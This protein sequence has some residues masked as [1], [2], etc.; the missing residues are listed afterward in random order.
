LDT[1]GRSGVAVL[2]DSG[3]H[4]LEELINVHEISLG[5]NSGQWKSILVLRL[6]STVVTAVTINRYQRWT[7]WNVIR[8][9]ATVDWKTLQCHQALANLSIR[10]GVN[11]TTLG[12]TKELV[13]GVVSALASVI[14]RVLKITAM[15]DWVVDWG[16]RGLLL[17]GVVTVVSGVMGAITG[18]S[19]M[20]LGVMVVVAAG[21]CKVLQVSNHFASLPITGSLAWMSML[22]WRAK[23]DGVVGVCLHVLLE[24]LRT[25]EC[26]ATEIALVGL[27][28]DVDTNVRGDVITLHSGGTAL[29]PATGQ[30]EVVCA[31]ASNVL[32]TDVFKEGLRGGTSLR[33]LVPLT[34]QVVISCNCWSGSLSRRGC[35]SIL[36]WLLCRS[37]RHGGYMCR[38]RRNGQPMSVPHVRS[39]AT[40]TSEVLVMYRE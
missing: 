19:G 14:G 34:G 40:L 15:A 37:G 8:D 25:L 24:I 28:G 23:K 30:V 39:G 13:Q 27:Q 21:S 38:S 26:L 22:L 9:A 7:S 6:V 4:L 31:L 29:I 16:V 11:L 5:T 20:H 2:I 35:R 1:S 17:R 36:L 3:L 10:A 18:S 32:L 12:I 33:T